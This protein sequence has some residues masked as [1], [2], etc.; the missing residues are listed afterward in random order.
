M[1]AAA[2]EIRHEGRERDGSFFI[3]R[4]GRRIAE[5]TYRMM[6]ADAMLDHTWV[7]PAVRGR[8]DA[9]RLVDA[10]AEW[11]RREH[12]KLVPACSYVRALFARS[13]AYADVQKR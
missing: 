13:P 11:A 5:L 9:K 2:G 12:L 3:E 10:A 4:D 6:G 1:S 7:D 8:G